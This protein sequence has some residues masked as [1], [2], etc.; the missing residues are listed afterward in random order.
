MDALAQTALAAWTVSAREAAV[1]RIWNA[2]LEKSVH[3]NN[4]VQGSD[5]KMADVSHLVR[6]TET[7]PRERNPDVKRWHRTVGLVCRVGRRR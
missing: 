7:A 2:V 5:S 1:A 6:A 3:S 4:T